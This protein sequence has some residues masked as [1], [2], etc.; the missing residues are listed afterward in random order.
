MKQLVVLSG[1]G[2]TGKTS[3]AA[4]F[5]ILAGKC[6]CADCDVDASDLHLLLPPEATESHLFRSGQEAVV[7]PSGCDACGICTS[8]CR[9]NAIQF[10]TTQSGEEVAQVVPHLCEGCAVCV[11]LCPQQAI[12]TRPRTSGEWM[13]SKARC[14]TM[15][16][17]RLRPGAENSGQLVT[18][19]RTQAVHLAEEQNAEL[20]VID[21]PP[22][23]GCPVIAAVSGA[24]MVL[25]VTEPTVSGEH[26]LERVLSLTKHFNIATAICVNK[27][28]LNPEMTER[29]EEKARRA[30]ARVV[31][32][33]RYDRAVTLAQMQERAVVEIE[34][35][36][37]E[38]IQGIW[39][40]LEL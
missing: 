31:G 17:A 21:G 33:I 19:V 16:H 34:A 24:T 36:C 6:V 9:F 5:S 29:I 23:V 22:G 4:S 28:D 30:G 35:P 8:I 26:D 38:D 37:V 32:R 2:G 27:W 20:V 40:Q 18:A 10:I 25:A 7:N 14:G 39:K 11:L 13:V 1:K 3:L 15:V 12:Q